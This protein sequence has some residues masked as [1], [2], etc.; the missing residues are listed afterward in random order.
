MGWFGEDDGEGAGPE[1]VNEGLVDFGDGAGMVGGGEEGSELGQGGDVRYEGVVGGTGFSPVDGVDGGGVCCVCAE[2]I[3]GF[4]GE[5]D[6]FTGEKEG[7]GILEDGLAG[8]IGDCVFRIFVR[9][10]GSF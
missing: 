1:A 8:W 9:V 3:D 4:C 2:T 5:G 7:G 6:D 10:K